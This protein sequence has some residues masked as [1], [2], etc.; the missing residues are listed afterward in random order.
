MEVFLHLN[1]MNIGTI[2]TFLN[3]KNKTLN[4]RFGV[5]NEDAIKLVESSKDDLLNAINN[6]GFDSVGISSFLRNEN[7]NIMNAK[8]SLLDDVIYNDE[9]ATINSPNKK[10]KIS[11]TLFDFKA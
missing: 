8:E 4:L 7:M 9:P 10:A 5:G 3:F 6:L 2:D 1:T 11:N